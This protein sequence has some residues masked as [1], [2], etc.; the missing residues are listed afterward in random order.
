MYE[1]D[2][3]KVHPNNFIV[4]VC[5]NIFLLGKIQSQEDR[6]YKELS[7]IDQL[8]LQPITGRTFKKH[9]IK[10]SSNLSDA[11]KNQMKVTFKR[12]HAYYEFT[13]EIENVSKEKELI[14][15]EKVT[16]PTI[17]LIG[18]DIITVLLSWLYSYRRRRKSQRRLRKQ[19]IIVIIID[20]TVILAMYIQETDSEIFLTPKASSSVLEQCGLIGEGVKRPTFEDYRV[21][22][23]STGSGARHL[24]IGSMVLY[25]HV[26]L[27]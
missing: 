21:F 16:R 7:T 23:Q 24:P 15:V 10:K 8:N 17:I 1:T 3:I 25:E 4:G 11:I 22:V 14:F 6:G 5:C 18:N 19:T 12:G 9:R 26:R 27:I 20:N 2:S 13:H